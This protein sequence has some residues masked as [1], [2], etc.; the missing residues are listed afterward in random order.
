MYNTSGQQTE[1]G[2]ET[3]KGQQQ[4][5]VVLV[6]DVAQVQ[7]GANWNPGKNFHHLAS[8]SFSILPEDYI[9]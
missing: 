9:F 4:H 1:G 3:G 2:G 8:Y 5:Q 7:S 6:K